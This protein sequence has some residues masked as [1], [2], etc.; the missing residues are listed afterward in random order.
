M[1]ENEQEESLLISAAIAS[2]IGVYIAQ[3]GVFR[4]ANV[5]FQEYTG[6]T[7]DELLGTET[8]SLVAPDD[9]DSVKE[10]AISMLKGNRTAPYEFRVVTKG[11]EIRWVQE[12]VTSIRLRGT[13]ALV[14]SFVDITERRKAE[15]ELQ[16]LYS[17]EKGMRQ[18]LEAERQKRIEFTRALV[19]ELKTPITPVLAATEMLLQ[20]TKD[21]A[22][23][24]LVESI[25]RS[26]SNLNRRIDDFMDLIRGETDMLSLDLAPLN[27]VS[28]LEDLAQEMTP[29]TANA[30]RSLAIDLPLSMPDIQA[31]SDRL[32]QVVQN[33]LNNAIKYSPSGGTITLTALVDGTSLVVKVRDTGQGIPKD[34]LAR[35]FDPYFRRVQDRARLGG[36]GLGLALSKKLVELHGGE[37]W[38]TSGKKGT[39]FCFSMPLA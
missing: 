17:L 34:D 33:L 10:N 8:L 1:E 14:G 24:R 22:S 38:V 23:L 11:G 27:M 30:G 28:L 9:R 21:E 19:H 5:T 18:E 36:L 3:G 35:L 16:R 12:S 2:L 25:D 7:E 37:M 29:V 39:T 4:F 15:E 13:P 6:Y 32:R 26:T 31:D 20:R